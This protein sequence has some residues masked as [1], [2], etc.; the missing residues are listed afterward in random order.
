MR[1][2]SGCRLDLAAAYC[3]KQREMWP[4]ERSARSRRMPEARLEAASARPTT[5]L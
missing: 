5:A 2:A 1:H 3:G 4:A